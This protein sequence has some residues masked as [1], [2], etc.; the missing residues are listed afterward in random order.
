M[1]T[2]LKT[3]N[4][5]DEIG[6]KNF[7]NTARSADLKPIENMFNIARRKLKEQAVAEKITRKTFE[8][9]FVSIVET[10]K[11]FSIEIIDKII[12]S[13]PKRTKM[14]VKSKVKGI[15]Y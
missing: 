4:V 15:K 1:V 3:A 2:P 12:E 11:K 5:F 13:I 6:R 8:K 10:L 9:F 14:I 7:S